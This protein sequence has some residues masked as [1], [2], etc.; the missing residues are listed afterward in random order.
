MTGAPMLFDL[1]NYIFFL[2]II[3]ALYVAASNFIQMNMGGKGRFKQV[4]EEMKENQKKMMEATKAKRDAESSEL[5]SQ[6]MKL[7]GEMMKLQFMFLIPILII[8]IGLAAFFPTVEPGTS[9]DVRLPLFD[10][11][12]A[13]HCDATAA[14]GI[15]SNCYLIPASAQRGAWMIDAHLYSPENESLVRNSTAIFIDG[16]SPHDVW[17]Q[18][19]T[20]NGILDT[21]AGKKQ[22][23]LGITTD[24]NNYTIGETVAIHSSASQAN[25]SNRY[26]AVLNSGT[27]FYVDL[28]FA[29]PLLNISRI[30]GSYGVFIFLAF[31]ISI[32][33]SIAKA[34]HAAVKKKQQ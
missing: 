26:E 2:A 7:T 15:Y 14:D 6:Y 23:A 30:I 10:D 11:G 3:A 31:V 8:F 28:P 1:S 21:L 33:Y 18:S 4:Q 29:L 22:H 12:L 17:L 9:D 27:F 20:Q 5:M 24:R 25:P 34:I 13:A 32:C 19:Q 16:G